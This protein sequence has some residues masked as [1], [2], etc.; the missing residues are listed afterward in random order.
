MRFCEYFKIIIT[1]SGREYK[2]YKNGKVESTL[3]SLGGENN[4]LPGD[5]AEV[6]KISAIEDLVDFAIAVNGGI[7][8][9]GKTVTLD[10]TNIRAENGDGCSMTLIGVLQQQNQI[11]FSNIS[12][13]RATA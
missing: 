12:I 1:K 2:V 11:A 4:D 8:Y 13:P 3:G 10:S 6:L 9:E 5:N 7:T